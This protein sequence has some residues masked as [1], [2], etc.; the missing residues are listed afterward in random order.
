MISYKTNCHKVRNMKK[1]LTIA[2][3][4]VMVPVMVT[5]CSKPAGTPVAGTPAAETPIAGAPLAE[6]PAAKKP[7]G[8]TAADIRIGFSVRSRQDSYG[9]A[10]S[11]S[12][13]SACDA[14]GLICEILDANGDPSRQGS[15]IESFIAEGYDAIAIS[16]VDESALTDVCAKANEAGIP[17]VSVTAMPDAVVAVTVN[18]GDHEFSEK[19]GTV[20]AGIMGGE[21]KVALLLDAPTGLWRTQQR[22]QAFKDVIAVTNIEIAAEEKA[23][24]VDEAAVAAETLMAAHPDLTAIWGTGSGALRG[25]AQA[26]KT[27]GVTNL[28]IGGGADCDTA[29]LQLMKEGFI[30]AAAAQFPHDHGKILAEAAIAMALDEDFPA[31]AYAPYKVYTADQYALAS[32]EVWGVEME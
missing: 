19:A 18:A 14:A 15:D 7:A 10:C 3:I 21:G 2:L 16:P 11:E 24:T 17:L 32:M 5:A 30:Q 26:A 12:F 31:V 8:K 25:A 27:A 28:V 29:V 6:A 9:V 22:L 4:A 23:G 1:I 13:R 20:L